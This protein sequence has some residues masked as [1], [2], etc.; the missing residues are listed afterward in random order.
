MT[1]EGAGIS[2]SGPMWHEFITKVL[3]NLPVENFKIPDFIF[4]EKIMLNGQ[5]SNYNN[6]H[7]IHT[8]LHYIKLDNPTGESPQELERDIQ[9]NNWEWS[10]VNY[11]KR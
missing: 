10:V 4:S 3:N 6:E 9:Y 1:K 5:Y 8:I 2:A 7:Q 11:F